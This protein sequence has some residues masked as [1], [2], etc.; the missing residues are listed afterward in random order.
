MKKLI[1]VALC[2]I[3]LLSAVSVFAFDDPVSVVIDG[4]PMEFSDFYGY[5]VEYK[6]R[7]MLPFRQIFETYGWN[8][9]Y[10][11]ETESIIGKSG[12]RFIAMQ[13]G[14]LNYFNENGKV[15][16]DVEPIIVNDRTMV[17]IRV[18]SEILGFKVDWDEATTTVIITTK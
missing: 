1:S 6:D 5:P 4:T 18:V 15:E 3:M 16:F 9:Y 12:D 8:A 14:S 17:P 7:V 10:E 11:E 2:T 13:K